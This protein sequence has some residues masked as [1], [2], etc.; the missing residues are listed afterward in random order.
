LGKILSPSIPLPE[1]ERLV[2]VRTRNTLAN[3]DADAAP[4][5]PAVVVLRYDMRFLTNVP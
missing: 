2:L 4:G 3:Q 1:G 5:A